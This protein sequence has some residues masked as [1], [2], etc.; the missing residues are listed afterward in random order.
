MCVRDRE[1]IRMGKGG[2]ERV[3]VKGKEERQAHYAECFEG[4]EKMF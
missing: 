3:R 4:R 1:R 2:R